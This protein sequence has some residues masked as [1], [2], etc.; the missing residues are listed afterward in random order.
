[1]TAPCSGDHAADFFLA[2]RAQHV[3]H[4]STRAAALEDHVVAAE[5]A[6]LVVAEHA[7]Q[8]WLDVVGQQ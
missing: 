5:H 4:A 7:Q 6:H 1:V 2:E 3:G 8:Q